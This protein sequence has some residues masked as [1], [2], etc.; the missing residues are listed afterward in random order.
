MITK[1]ALSL[2]DVRRMAT[3]AEAEAT[4]NG[5]AMV[6]AIVDDGGHLLWFERLDGGRAGTVPIAIGKAETAARFQAPT[7]AFED[8]TAGRLTFL[9]VPGVLPL[10]GGVPIIVDGQCVGAIGVSGG[11]SE[12]DVQVAEA[13]IAALGG[14]K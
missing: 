2:A 9:A 6:I 1:P 8:L 3:A 11:T 5:W 4:R 10:E 12:Q 13:G 14:V 7:K